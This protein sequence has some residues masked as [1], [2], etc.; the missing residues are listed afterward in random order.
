[1]L[2]SPISRERGI[3]TL[4]QIALVIGLVG[5]V[6]AAVLVLPAGTLPARAARE[7]TVAGRP[8]EDYLDGSAAVPDDFPEVMGYTPVEI[9]TPYGTRMAAPGGSCSSPTGDAGPFFDFTY[10]C[11]THDLGYDLLRYADRVGPPP[12]PDARL[13]VDQRFRHDM[14]RDCSAPGSDLV[15]PICDGWANIYT[16]AVTGNSIRQSYG[17]P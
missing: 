11:K 5:L 6:W 12:A 17:I 14:Y 8:I 16:M 3:G 1:M 13:A 15:E 4:G 10:P 9:H 7:S 2:I